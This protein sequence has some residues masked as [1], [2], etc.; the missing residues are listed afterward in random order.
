M[1]MMYGIL[2]PKYVNEDGKIIGSYNKKQKI[3]EYTSETAIETMMYQKKFDTSA[4][5]KLYKR[6]LFNNI[7][8]PVG[9]LYEDI[10]TIYKVLFKANKIF[11][12]NSPKYYYLQ[13]STS[14][15]GR[16]FKIQDLD[17]IYEAN[18]LI[19]DE[20]IKNNNKLYKAAK[21]RFINANF[22]ILL[23]IKKEKKKF[24]KEKEYI[25]S[26]IKKYRKEVFFNLN[27]RMKT[28]IAI[29]LNYIKI[30]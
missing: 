28:K 13:R 29:L 9:K 25:L 22:S 3:H 11:Y 6:N 30:I 26:N 21:C 10:G 20:R 16:K 7:R 12:I 23:K 27:S 5:G 2:I 4:W 19:T 24:P 8:F 15:M 14:I 17:Y 1:I 18:K